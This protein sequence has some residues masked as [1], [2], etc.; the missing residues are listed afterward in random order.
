LLEERE[1][2]FE[3]V[4]LVEEFGYFVGEFDMPEDVDGC[5]GGV[6]LAFQLHLFLF[7]PIDFLFDYLYFLLLFF[8]GFLVVLFGG[9]RRWLEGG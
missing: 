7:L 9:S 3:T 6:L 8:I 5:S 4:L 1:G 2:G